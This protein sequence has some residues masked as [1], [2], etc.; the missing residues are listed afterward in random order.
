M[1]QFTSRAHHSIFLFVAEERPGEKRGTGWCVRG[2]RLTR[3]LKL[4]EETDVALVTSAWSEFRRSELAHC[5][6]DEAAELIDFRVSDYHAANDLKTRVS[7]PT[8]ST[9]AHYATTLSG[10]DLDD[11]LDSCLTDVLIPWKKGVSCAGRLV[12]RTS[13]NVF[14]GCVDVPLLIPKDEILGCE[15]GRANKRARVA[16]RSI[17]PEGWSRNNLIGARIHCIEMYR[18]FCC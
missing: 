7:V 9:L 17:M 13:C 1:D 11:A 2:F 12:H 4:Q 16:E 8:W 14:S 15:E 10:S 5:A 18:Y 3:S 6:V